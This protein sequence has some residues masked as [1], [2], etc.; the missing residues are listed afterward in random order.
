MTNKVIAYTIKSARDLLINEIKIA[1]EQSG[2]TDIEV[3]VNYCD[4]GTI[5]SCYISK[6]YLDNE[7]NPVVVM[8]EDNED[9]PTLQPIEGF[10]LD[11]IIK[12]IG[13][14]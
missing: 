7:G 1:L 4:M 5:C 14:M 6:I 8:C 12:I 3:T 10:S 9:T 2:E 11:E 13:A